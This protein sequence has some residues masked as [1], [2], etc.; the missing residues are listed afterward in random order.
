M[1]ICTCVPYDPESK[2]GSESSVKIAKADLVPTDANLLDEYRSFAE[3]EAA[4]AA[5]MATFNGRV[6]SVPWSGPQRGARR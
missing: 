1:T 2:G 5:A 6:H 3:L 4:C